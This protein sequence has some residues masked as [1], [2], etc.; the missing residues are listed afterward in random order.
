MKKIVRLTESDLTRIVK[1]VINE[2]NYDDDFSQDEYDNDEDFNQ[3]DYDDLINQDDYDDLINQAK[4]FL[5]EFEYDDPE[6]VYEMSDME[7]IKIIKIMDKELYEK[8]QNIREREKYDADEP[9]DAIGGLS[10]NDVKKMM[11]K[12]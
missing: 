1:R 7:V 3:D 2:I 12:K 4:E 6:S 10:P 5:I 9:Y 11:L 8:I